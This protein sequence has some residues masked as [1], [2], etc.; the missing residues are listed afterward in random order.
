[1]HSDSSLKY[2]PRNAYPFLSVLIKFSL[3]LLNN[4]RFNYIESISKKRK[5]VDRSAWLVITNI[6][7]WIYT[8]DYLPSFSV[9]KLIPSFLKNIRKTFL[10]KKERFWKKKRRIFMIHRKS[11]IYDKKIPRNGF[12]EGSRWGNVLS[13]DNTA[14]Y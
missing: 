3:T 14:R 1:M 11:K 2:L 9:L 13:R 7:T 6:Y 8:F 4:T 5:F 12:Q 10:L